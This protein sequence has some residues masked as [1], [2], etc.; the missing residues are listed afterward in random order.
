MTRPSWEEYALLLA[1]AA[2][3]RSEDPY[4]RVGACVLR[5]DHSV[6]SVGYNG[7]PSG[8]DIDWS[9]RSKRRGFTIH[10]EANALRYCRPLEGT[11]IACTLSPCPEC[12]KLIAS[13]KIDRVV[14]REWYSTMSDQLLKARELAKVFGITMVHMPRSNEPRR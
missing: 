11:V 2:S 9:S 14:F 10:A 13:H 8:V 3:T 6:A 1:E 7:A 5:G 12:L 4:V